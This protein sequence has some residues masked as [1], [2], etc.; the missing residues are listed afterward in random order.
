MPTLRDRRRVRLVLVCRDAFAEV[1]I[2]IYKEASAS[3]PVGACFPGAL[4]LST[5][6]L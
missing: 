1:G 4:R 3:V 2:A 6:R 5:R